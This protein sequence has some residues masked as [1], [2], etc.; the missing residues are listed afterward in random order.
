MLD[1]GLTLEVNRCATDGARNACSM[2]YGAAWRAAQA[3]GYVRVVTYTL[4]SEGGF[5]L[6]AV[7]WKPAPTTTEGRG[8]DC[9]SRPRIDTHPLQAKLRWEVHA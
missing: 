5:S 2:L 4:T 1:D 9:A 7:G 8:W 6:R 3:L